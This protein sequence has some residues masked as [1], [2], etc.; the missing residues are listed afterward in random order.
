MKTPIWLQIKYAKLFGQ[1]RINLWEIK[2]N[3]PFLGNGRCPV[4]GDSTK[5]Q[6]KKRF[7]VFEKQGSLGCSC[8]NCGFGSSIENLLKSYDEY[9]YRQLITE[10][11]SETSLVIETDEPKKT[12][13][14][15]LTD[16]WKNC[17]VPVHAAP[18]A[19]RYLENRM[20]PRKTWSRLYFT[21]NLKHTYVDICDTLNIDV[22]S[23]KK[24]PEFEGIFFPFLDSN[25][26]LAFST[27]RNLDP[28]SNLRYVTIEFSPSYKIFGS[29]CVDTSKPIRVLE[30]PID[31]LC[32]NNAVAV[33]DA[34]LD[35]ASQVFD[36]EN[37]VLIPDNESRAPVQLKRIE[38][39]INN[40]YNVV[41][42]P[43]HIKQ[44][45]L[46]EMLK[47]GLDVES[48]IE[49]NTFKGLAAKL[50]F[51]DWKKL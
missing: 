41:I 36:K 30:G 31:S 8:H 4:C 33:G 25:K 14:K 17:L 24:I 9:L 23:S 38:G 28:T 20:I 43:D 34:S 44:K 22:D 1:Q 15:I 48:I 42:F 47:A 19:I 39:F 45:D 37:L 5:N 40:G 7:Y 26:K 18:K 46:N 32:C 3:S 12:K 27:L 6:T 13:P 35:R 51:K 21:E 2:N 49:L 11:F 50:R 10:R 29:E 16:E